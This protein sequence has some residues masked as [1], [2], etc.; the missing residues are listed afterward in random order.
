MTLP[1]CSVTEI[2]LKLPASLVSNVNNKVWHCLSS[3]HNQ[4]IFFCLKVLLGFCEKG[5]NIC[6][7]M[8]YNPRC[9]VWGTCEE[10]KSEKLNLS[11]DFIQLHSF[12]CFLQ[13]QELCAGQGCEKQRQSHD[14][15]PWKEE[16]VLGPQPP[17][18][19]NSFHFLKDSEQHPPS[20]P[21]SLLG[22]VS[23]SKQSK[24]TVQNTC[25]MPCH[26]SNIAHA[27]EIAIHAEQGQDQ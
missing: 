10:S 16:Q 9:C 2:Q 7:G 13:Q 17:P 27:N 22:G 5:F 24:T 6:L 18:P 11:R 21:R 19:V 12:Q 4:K 3:L 23:S 8:G 15:L 1:P 26:L 20:A 25:F 14:N